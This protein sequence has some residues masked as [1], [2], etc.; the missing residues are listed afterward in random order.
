MKIVSFVPSITETLIECGVNVVGRTR[1]CIHPNGRVNTIPIVGGT[2]NVDWEKLKSLQADYI[3]LDKEENTAE[4]AQACPIPFI[5]THVLSM[6]SLSQELLRLSEILKNKELAK[7]S[8]RA[9]KISLYSAQD[10]NMNLFLSKILT[11]KLPNMKILCPWPKD[12]KNVLYV[13][14]KNP[15]MA[16]SRGTYIGSVCEALGFQLPEFPNLYPCIDFESF[17][18]KNTLLLFSSEPYPFH[19]IENEISK[20]EFPSAV[21]DGEA[22]SWFGIRS[23]RFLEDFYKN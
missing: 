20:M 16:V 23:I 17:D 9:Q 18:K 21:V 8:E 15:W 3:L 12:I 13:I 7:L 5:S 22:F 1:F 6:N 10:K 4:M 14:W 11:G 19:K 2:K